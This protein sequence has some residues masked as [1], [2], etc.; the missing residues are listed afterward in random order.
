MLMVPAETLRL[1]MQARRS[2]SEALVQQIAFAPL[3]AGQQPIQGHVAGAATKDAVEASAQGGGPARAGVTPPGLEVGVEPPDQLPFT[4]T[5]RLCSAVAGSSLCTR[6]S[7]WTQQ[8]A[9]GPTRNW[10]AS[11]ET[12]IVA[13]AQQGE[14]E[15]VWGAN[16]RM[17]LPALPRTLRQRARP[18]LPY[19]PA[20]G[21]RSAS[22]LWTWPFSPGSK[23]S[24]AQAS[25]LAG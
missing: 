25:G 17:G 22:A 16:T 20:L 11:S 9:W 4:A 15:E 2:F 7:A 8:S 18:T 1:V 14:H 24:E 23:G 21:A 3:Q 6:R 5:A 12:I 10:P 13:G 19:G